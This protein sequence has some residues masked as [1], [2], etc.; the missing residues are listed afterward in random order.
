MA[1]LIFVRSRKSR[2]SRSRTI[3][4]AQIKP[5]A[6]CP[7]LAIAPGETISELLQ[8]HEMSILDFARQ[9]GLAEDD[10]I[11]LLRGE[12][13]I[14][15]ELAQSLADIFELPVH[16]WANLEENYR[17]I[18]ERI[19][20]EKKHSEEVKFSKRF[21]VVEMSRLGWI[22]SAS[23]INLTESLLEFFGI[24]SWQDFSES[25]VYTVAFRKSPTRIASNFALA[26]WLR[27]GQLDADQIDTAAFDSEKLRSRII[28]LRTLTRLEF[29]VFRP[30]I[31]EICRACGVAVVFVPL[32]SKCYVSG[33]AYHSSGKFIVQ[34]SSRFKTND[35]FWFSLFHELAHVIFHHGDSMFVDD[36]E[37]SADPREAIAN[38]YAANTLLPK[39]R[40]SEWWSVARPT[41]EAIV[42]FADKVG[43]ASGIVVGRL[44]HDHL[45]P[46]DCFN[47]LKQQI[48]WDD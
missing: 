45:I 27:R 3:T 35:H 47:D 19:E 21:P 8:E 23:E 42:A 28:E 12:I 46:Y 31:V 10:S 29:A 30:S 1:I 18:A 15:A 13:R 9:V 14:S 24:P 43:I 6:Y 16:F 48:V 40:Y 17:R 39:E 38:D 44:Q 7:S 37:Y 26:A 33:A 22:K 2:S 4:V 5:T 32:L 11:A 41:R 36:F 34:L 20:V 25:P